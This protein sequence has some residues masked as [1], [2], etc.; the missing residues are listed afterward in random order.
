MKKR[1]QIAAILIMTIAG[2][3]GIA[4]AQDYRYD[5]RG[6]F[7]YY[8]RDGM[9]SARQFGSRDGASVAREDMWKGK[10]FNPNPRGPFSGADDGYR[11]EFGSRRDYRETYAQAYREAYENSF[12]DRRY[13]R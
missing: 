2:T 12:R 3:A 1:L 7:G 11:H 10:P 13:Y 6:G 5:D 8:D 9:Q 4:A